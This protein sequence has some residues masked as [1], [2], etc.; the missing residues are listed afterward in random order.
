M[1]LE[2][3]SGRR[4]GI[5]ERQSVEEK[6]TPLPQGRSIFRSEALETYARNQ[7]RAIF[8]QLISPRGFGLL[9]VLA[10]LFLAA[11]SLIGFW[12]IIGPYLAGRP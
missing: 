5:S 6:G 11:G 2:P 10:C 3:E 9:W 7:E 1:S 12:P 4:Q 8:P